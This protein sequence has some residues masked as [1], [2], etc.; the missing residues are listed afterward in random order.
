MKKLY[1]TILTA[2][3]ALSTVSASAQVS[4]TV[5]DVLTDYEA[6][7]TND[8]YIEYQ[9]EDYV[10]MLDLNEV[11][12]V[13]KTYT[14]ANSADDEYNA[15]KNKNE[16]IINKYGTSEW[17]KYL[18][19]DLSLKFTQ[20]DVKNKIFKAEA[21]VEAKNGSDVIKTKFVY[22][23]PSTIS[24]TL[25]GQTDYNPDIK[26]Y[27]LAAKNKGSE[28]KD[29]YSIN[30][31]IKAAAYDK[32]TITVSDLYGKGNKIK[33]S[34]MSEAS[35]IKTANLTVEASGN[36]HIVKGDITDAAGNKYN[37]VLTTNIPSKEAKAIEVDLGAVLTVTTDEGY[38]KFKAQDGVHE[39]IGFIT[40][41][42]TDVPTGTYELLSYSKYGDYSKAFDFY[43]SDRFENGQM[44]VV[45]NNGNISITATF[46]QNGKNYSVKAA[47]F[48]TAI[49]TATVAPAKAA[50]KFLENGKIVIVKDGKKYGVDAAEVK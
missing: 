10:L 31:D 43:M 13:G 35:N 40:C 44:V 36:S 4:E 29:D 20:V 39:F 21:T 38:I 6:Y 30:L 12:T 45:N 47:N 49:T 46:K 41:N 16:I 11:P 26:V 34:S 9:N 50:S 48:T 27:S 33:M 19:T 17:K 7:K 5:L 18:I 28:L 8:Q 22:N 23:A 2:L 14:M 32:G 37:V 42:T 3:A 15:I 24:F 1:R 25:D